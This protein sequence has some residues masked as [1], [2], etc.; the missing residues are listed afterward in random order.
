MSLIKEQVQS[1]WDGQPCGSSEVS[2]DRGSVE[3]LAAHERIRYERE[4]MIEPFADFGGWTGRKVLEVGVGMGADHVRFRKSG[5]DA[6]G[7]DLS[8]ESLRLASLRAA[9]Q[10]V[11]VSLMRAD[12]EALPFAENWF[13]MV[14]SWG[15]LMHV[16]DTPRAIHEVHRVL[17]PGGEC[18]IMLYNRHSLN[19][20]QIYLFYGLL[21]GKP[22]AKVA[23]LSREHLESPGTKVYT[24]K[25]VMQLFHEFAHVEVKPAV[26]VYDVRLGR[27]RFAPQWMLRAVPASLG[28]F[29]LIRARK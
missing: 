19:A 23:D 25:E 17:K 29:L 27:R 3:F 16:P 20:L 5:A 2:E 1:Y 4:P 8:P 28:W 9:A 14:Y 11:S 10:G 24:Q 12:A 13:D 6:V 26:T 15:V 18:R 7:V 21:R 22:L